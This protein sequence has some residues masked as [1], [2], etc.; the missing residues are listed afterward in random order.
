[1]S[2]LAPTIERL[3]ETGVN[4]ELSKEAQLL[5]PTIEKIV[6]IAVSKG[7]HVTLDA[8]LMLAPSLEKLAL[9]GGKNLTIRF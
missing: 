6:A 5:A 4:I 8:S 9:I 3:A 2:M 1:M 7:A